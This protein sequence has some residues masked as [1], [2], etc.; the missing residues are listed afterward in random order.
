[1]GGDAAEN[2]LELRHGQLRRRTSAHVDGADGR[3]G[4]KSFGQFAAD[5]IGVL[6]SQMERSRREEIAV[7]AARF[8]EGDVYVEAGC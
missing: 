3:V 1:M 8:A 6:A 7:D 5:R 2:L 4:V